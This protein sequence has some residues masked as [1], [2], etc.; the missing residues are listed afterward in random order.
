MPTG[1]GSSDSDLASAKTQA[2]G[3]PA[4]DLPSDHVPPSGG[5]PKREEA[6]T[7]STSDQ[8]DPPQAARLDSLADFVGLPGYTLECVLGQGGM[9]V[10]FRAVELGLKRVVAVKMLRA[11]SQ[12]GVTEVER[13]RI[14]VEAAARLDHRHIVP[15]YHVGEHR[16]HHYFTMK[17]VEG[18]SLATRQAEFSLARSRLPAGK[19]GQGDS[20]SPSITAPAE[21]QVKL[22]T[23]MAKVARAVQCAHDQGILHRDLKPGNILLDLAR[24]PHV[25]DFG[26]AKRVDGDSSLTQTG[27]ILGTPSYM[28]PEQASGKKQLTPAA[29][30]YSL[31]A[32]LYELL[33]GRPPHKAETPV[34]TIIQVMH[35]DPPRPSTLNR[36]VPRDLET[37]CVKALAKDPTARYASA[38]AL[39]DDLERFAAGQPIKAR[40]ARWFERAWRRCRRNP[41]VAGLTLSVLALALTLGMMVYRSAPTSDGSLNRVKAAGELVIAIDTGFAPMTFLQD[42]RPVGFEIDVSRE[43]A[44]RLGVRAT[45]RPVE[46]SWRDVVAGLGTGHCDMVIAAWN[47]TADR[48]QDVGFVE[49]L[50]LTQVFVCRAGAPAVRNEKDLDGKVVIIGENTVQH[51]YVKGLK[52]RGLPIK[53]IRFPP[54]GVAG[55]AAVWVKQGLGDVTLLEKPVALYEARRDPEIVVTGEVGHS[56]NPEPLGMVLRKQDRQLQEA[57]AAAIRAMQDDGTFARILQTWFAE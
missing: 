8:A 40:P 22:A 38:G 1:S 3:V 9:G 25:A 11:G 56:M 7:V 57:A 36:A 46:W 4:G 34:E 13:F 42:D 45:Y 15:I 31:G 54:E 47:I 6:D 39:A 35:D 18:G 17:L 43:V 33:T 10:V 51:R 23:L 24:E 21:R 52:D 12:A 14:E 53:E 55:T 29:D 32:I 48:A 26:L 20:G 37:I 2:P 16:G 28:P 19:A 50:R 27:A 41:I 30:V 49:Y 44:S 5:A